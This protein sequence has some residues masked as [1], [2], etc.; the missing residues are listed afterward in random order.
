MPRPSDVRRHPS[1][2][3]APRRKSSAN[4]RDASRRSAPATRRGAAASL[5]VAA[6][7]LWQPFC[8]HVLLRLRA[9]DGAARS[10]VETRLDGFAAA[11]RTR[12]GADGGPGVNRGGVNV[13]APLL[14]FDWSVLDTD[15]NASCGNRKCFYR[16][17]AGGKTKEGYLVAKECLPDETYGG[18]SY[19]TDLRAWQVVHRLEEK[20][21]MRHFLVGPP[22]RVTHPVGDAL[23]RLNAAAEIDP[24]LHREF[25]GRSVRTSR[26][27]TRSLVVQRVRAAPEPHLVPRCKFTDRGRGGTFYWHHEEG[28]GAFGAAAAR[29]GRFLRTL[30][31]ELRS[32]IKILRREKRLWFGFQFL[33]DARGRVHHLD[34]DRI[35]VTGAGGRMREQCLP[36][37]KSAIGCFETIVDGFVDVLDAARNAT[38]VTRWEV[39]NAKRLAKAGLRKIHLPVGCRKYGGPNGTVKG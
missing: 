8:H 15:R 34:T 23:A 10:V 33:V 11:A 1:S 16:S 26:C 38:D 5:V 20:E 25:Y 24:R 9:D 6:L 30:G 3:G 19:E 21:Q 2:D 31:E 14:D 12:G 7:L 29:H 39:A 35:E 32:L 13:S 28:V 17:R 22:L 27:L 36:R 18:Y 4:S 37:E